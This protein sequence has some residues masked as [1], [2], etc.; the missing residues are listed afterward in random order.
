M[1]EYSNED[2]IILDKSPYSEYFYQQTKSLDRGIIDAYGNHRMEKEIFKYKEI[3]VNAIVIF[4][5]NKN[6]WN[7]YINRETRKNNEEHKSSWK[8]LSEERYMDMVNMFRE[9]Q[10]VYNNTEKYKKMEIKNDNK[11]WKKVY[12][13]LKKFLSK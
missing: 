13:E 11:S 2:I 4:L 6:C 10:T 1:I 5:E 7:N 12:Q 3:I 8:T 9:H